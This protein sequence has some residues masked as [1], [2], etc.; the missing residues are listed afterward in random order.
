LYEPL[1]DEAPQ[2]GADSSHQARCAVLCAPT[3]LMAQ[4]GGHNGV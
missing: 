1:I 3:P 2:Q 4:F